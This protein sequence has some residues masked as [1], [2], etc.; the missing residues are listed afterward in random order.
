M[1]PPPP[2]PLLPHFRV[3][4]APPDLGRWSAG[5][6]G[7]AGAWSF[8]APQPGPHVMLVGLMHGNE[9]AGGIALSRLLEAGVRPLRGRLS[10]VFANLE[11][12]AGFDPGDPIAS[13]H[14]DEDMNRL[15][16]RDILDGPRD[17]AEL[18]RAR[19]LRPLIDTAD[20]LLDL[21]SMLYEGVP[22]VLCGPTEKARRL[23]M[24]I[25]APALVVSDEGHAAGRRLIDYR[26][27]ADPGCHRTA[28]LV[29]AGY[30]WAPGT[31]EVMTESVVRLLRLHEMIDAATALCLF[32]RPLG[33]IRRQLAQVTRT[34]TA[35]TDDFLFVRDFANG[36]VIAARNTLI[37]MDGGIE[38]RTPH[39]Q[40]LLVMPTPHAGKGHTAVRMARL[41]ATPS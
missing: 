11:A 40:C 24:S 39:D 15:W 7:L 25:G 21:H 30:H 28:V 18:R 5:N 9:I 35:A 23:A 26:P 41:V 2:H 4:L 20:T 6:T 31:V 36:E 14:V 27:F 12:F 8:P 29:E 13:R 16:C 32:P 34:V 38:V 1:R 22:L 17:T 3:A 10:V 19:A 33:A 37:A